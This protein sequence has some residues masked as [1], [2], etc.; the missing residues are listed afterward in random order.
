VG[1]HPQARQGVAA[2]VSRS[3]ARCSAF[4]CLST[5]SFS[6]CSGRD[7][8]PDV[9]P[10][11]DLG[12]RPPIYR[13]SSSSSTRRPA[14][15]D[16]ARDH[17]P[18]VDAQFD[19]G[20]GYSFDLLKLYDLRIPPSTSLVLPGLLARLRHQGAALPVPHLAARRHVEAPTPVRHPGRRAPEDGHLRPVAVRLPCSR[21][22]PPSSRLLALL[23]VIGSSTVRWSR[24]SSP[25]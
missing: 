7:A 17:R 1:I 16:A 8:H 25:T 23:A 21:R 19:H 5:C 10:H 18:R 3:R 4:S 14:A 9:L 12:L 11:R 24:W 20:A 15:P 22:L 13:R 2:F 6:T